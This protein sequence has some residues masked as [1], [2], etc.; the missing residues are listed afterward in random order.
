MESS[1]S[2][3][4][5]SGATWWSLAAATTVWSALHCKSLRWHRKE[6]NPPLQL[7]LALLKH[8]PL[9]PGKPG[10]FFMYK[11]F[12]YNLKTNKWRLWCYIKHWIKYWPTY[13]WPVDW[14][15]DQ[16]IDCPPPVLHRP[17]STRRS[18][19][20]RPRFFRQMQHILRDRPPNGWNL[21][22]IS[23]NLSR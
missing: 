17:M 19:T 18:W 15:I 5:N 11:P 2:Q 1:N 9:Y 23:T 8:W 12:P 13:T 6:I 21:L 14:L 3:F 16:L 7:L 10:N 4:N 22:K 20:R